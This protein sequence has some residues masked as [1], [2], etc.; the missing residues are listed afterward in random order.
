MES[1]SNRDSALVC[2]CVPPGKGTDS[3]VVP[4]EGNATQQGSTAGRQLLKKTK[5]KLTKTSKATG[6]LS[7]TGFDTNGNQWWNRGYWNLSSPQ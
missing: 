2:C 4:L 7:V 6:Q 5:A 1:A 3:N